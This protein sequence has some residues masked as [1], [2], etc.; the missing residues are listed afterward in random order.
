MSDVTREPVDTA[1]ELRT[2]PV[3][4]DEIT[5]KDA[6]LTAEREA[7]TAEL[8]TV[9]ERIVTDKARWREIDEALRLLDGRI[10]ALRELSMTDSR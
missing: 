8:A 4:V 9:K 7:L 3:T 1:A 5:T 10:A 6:T 2:E